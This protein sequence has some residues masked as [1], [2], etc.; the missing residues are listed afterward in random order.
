[1][2]DPRELSQSELDDLLDRLTSQGRDDTP[3][4]HAAYAEW[5]RRDV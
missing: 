5:E 4:F 2:S 3:E 1:M